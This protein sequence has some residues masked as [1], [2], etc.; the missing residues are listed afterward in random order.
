M[1]SFPM[2]PQLSRTPRLLACAAVAAW[3][4]P[5]WGDVEPAPSPPVDA[6][7]EGEGG[8][9]RKIAS[10][11]WSI[12]DPTDEEQLMLELMNRARVDPFGEG[13]RIFVDYGSA[14]VKRMVDFFIKQ[15]PGVEWSRAE[16]RD[17]FHGYPARMPLVFDPQ[18]TEAARIHSGLMREHD[19]QSHQIT[20]AGG[21]PIEPALRARVEA[22]GFF[23]GNLAESVFAF[24]D[25]MVH[26]HAG[27]SAD[28]GQPLEGARPR[29]GHRENLMDFD[30]RDY[31]LVGVGV[32]SDDDNKTKVGPLL[33]TI[34]FAQPAVSHLVPNVFVTGVV[35]HDKDE[36]GFYD[37]GEGLKDVRIDLDVGS[38]YAVS[39]ASGGYAVPVEG[40]PGLVRVTATAQPGTPAE[41]IVGTQT[42][43]VNVTD[44]SVKVD[45]GLPPDPPMPAMAA[46][47]NAASA[48][49][50]DSAAV[51]STVDAP[52]QIDVP[53]TVGVLEVDVS[54]T[55]PAREELKLTLIAPTGREVVL[56]D[57]GPAG[58]DV[59]GRFGVSLSPREPLGAFVGE[60]YVGTWTLKVEDDA[61]GND[62]TLVGWTLR[63][64]PEWVRPLHSEASSLL[65]TKLAT[66][67][68]TPALA[69]S[70]Q[71]AAVVD[72]GEVG[73]GRPGQARLRLLA[74]D[75][76]HAE[77]FSALLP[78]TAVKRA[79]GGTS[80]ATVSAKVSK[81]DLPAPMPASVEVELSIDDA[82]VRETVPLTKGAFNG[83]TTKPTS[84][85]FRI[86]TFKT[87]KP[88]GGVPTYQITGRIAPA[89]LGSDGPLEL[90][91]GA[92][93]E[94]TSIA[95]LAPKGKLFTMKG[96]KSLKSLT[97][98]PTKGSFTMTVGTALD[99]RPGQ[100]IDLALRLGDSAAFG[101][102]SV[103]PTE[104][105]SS[106]KY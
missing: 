75:A 66:K 90:I 76:T 10:V 11:Q 21:N 44:A 23:G 86:D 56:W 48:A 62:G 14:R 97:I 20:D 58:A 74:A 37:I 16:N 51:L 25:D 28:P 39:T 98:D 70:V 72:A 18:I 83:V 96:A 26:A 95:H 34:D 104:T 99:V 45:F 88:V 43:A 94:K 64:R 71:I 79:F 13:D 102:A 32:V 53:D 57:G 63:V 8:F 27:F 5:A 3:L 17:A 82:V 46:I 85:L 40:S 73:L 6:P 47:S 103:V 91:L 42:V 81:I 29:L 1:G 92:L 9:Q 15:R 30:E 55:H 50:D 33:V 52:A 77:L 78:A 67:S 89:T 4:V 7:G 80:K 41:A 87:L 49:V 105:G 12:G 24:A 106:L 65:V 2:Q 61:D 22:A 84:P 54:L 59:V 31:R 69:D 35:Y 38:T 60:S 93:R 36:D 100:T 101:A 19:Q 68:K